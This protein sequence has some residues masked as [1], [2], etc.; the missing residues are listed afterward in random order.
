MR[1]QAELAYPPA[2]LPPLRLKAGVHTG[3]CVAVTLND[4][5]DYFGTTVNIAARL[6][7]LTTAG[8]SVVASAAVINDPEVAAWRAAGG[9]WAEPFAATLK[10]YED[11]RFQLWALAPLEGSPTVR[12][13]RDTAREGAGMPV[14]RRP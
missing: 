11:E 4:R 8:T 6:E 2:G 12:A 5:L 14:S 1:A 7:G 3:P 10:G 13:G 9:A